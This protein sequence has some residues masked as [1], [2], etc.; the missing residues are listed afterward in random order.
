[1]TNPFQVMMGQIQNADKSPLW[2]I[3]TALSD[4][5]KRSTSQQHQP[6]FNQVFM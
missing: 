3:P 1:M 6:Q 2:S 5:L 4:F